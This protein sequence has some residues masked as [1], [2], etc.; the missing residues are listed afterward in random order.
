MS[1]MYKA[2]PFTAI[3]LEDSFWVPRMET[4]RLRTI[5]IEYS[6][7]K[8]TGR[9]DAFK[10]QWKPGMPNEPHIFWDSDVAKWIEAAAYT[11]ATTPD[12]DLEKLLDEVIEDIATAQQEDGY[13]NTHFTVVEPDKRWTNLRDLHELYCAGHMME[14]ATAYFQATGKRLLLD[15]MERYTDH[16]IS[17]FGKEESKKR[18]YCGHE[19]IE[20]ALI[21]MYHTTGDDKYLK[22]AQYFIDERG[23]SPLYFDIEAIARGEKPEDFWAKKYDYC[24]ADKPVRE[25]DK[26]AGHAVR[27][28][29]IYSAM[30]D[31]ARETNDIELRKA[32]DRIW[33][34]MTT[35]KI[36]ITGGIG[37]SAANE[38]FTAPY[39]LPNETAYA[40]TCAA[41]GLVFWAHR[42]LQ[43]ECDGK[44]ADEMECALY[45]GALSGVSLDGD[46]FFYANPLAAHP[47]INPNI[48]SW[49]GSNDYTYQ[50]S[51]W[52]GCACC[53]PNI[54]RL[55]A[56][57]GNYIYSVSE[58]TLAIHLYSA[59]TAKMQ[60]KSTDVT[61]RQ[62]TN[63][64]WDGQI[65]MMLEV[66]KPTEFTIKMRIPGWCDGAVASIN[67]QQINVAENTEH[68]Y[69]T[70]SRE[71]QTGD[72]ITLILPMPVERVYSHP[73]VRQNNG[74]VALQRGPIVYCIEQE[75]HTVPVHRIILPA[76][77][78][79][80]P[81]Y[82]SELLGGVV[83]IKGDA[84]TPDMTAWKDVL[85]RINRH[86]AENKIQL[87]A[88]PYYAWCNRTPGAMRVWI[89]ETGG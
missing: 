20:L 5:P 3:N 85:Y 10:L 26:I 15:V 17:V 68:G 73:D 89:P 12:K 65:A 38:G 33:D 62:L 14:A 71:W 21:K 43:L 16:I 66:A 88:I 31:L 24:Q 37:P 76:Q 32:C 22:Q 70:I 50:R 51:E 57:I 77:A 7:C 78:E 6:Q 23:K 1:E 18:G 39:D 4:N 53:P 58:N 27:A 41:I 49:A 59:G 36:Y 64:P 60:V 34:D 69:L 87:T 72:H 40:E 35:G 25:H 13:L 8:D 2:V 86:G 55:I 29:Y 83:V 67:G 46:K 61:V 63:Y 48:N 44:Y 54:A 82:S 28:M 80:Q 84:I 52:F 30:A 19:E 56:S 75:D 42:M 79:L 81:E 9:I 45:N 47:G 11:L 74:C